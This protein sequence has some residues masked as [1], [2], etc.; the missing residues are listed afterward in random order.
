MKWN[1]KNGKNKVLIDGMGREIPH[2]YEYDDET[3][4]A[5]IFIKGKDGMIVDDGRL[6][7]ITVKLKDAK[8]VDK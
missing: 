6:L 1:P 2:V 5:K 3:G 8:I 4:I 7:A